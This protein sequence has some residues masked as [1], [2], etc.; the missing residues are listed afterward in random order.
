MWDMAAA[1]HPWLKPWKLGLYVILRAA[2]AVARNAMPCYAHVAPTP[3][4]SPQ[5]M[6][7]SVWRQ[8]AMAHAPRP[9]SPTVTVAGVKLARADAELALPVEQFAAVAKTLCNFPSFFAAPLF[10]RVL[11]QFRGCRLSDSE[12]PRR[13]ATAVRTRDNGRPVHGSGGIVSCAEPRSQDETDI[14]APGSDVDHT[15]AAGVVPLYMFLRYWRSEMEPF[16]RTDRFFRLVA[17]RC[18][19][20]QDRRAIVPS[21]FTPLLEELLA[22]HPG[23]GFLE[24][25]PEFQEKYARTVIARIFFD[26]DAMARGMIWPRSLRRSRLVDA[27]HTVDMEEDINL[28]NH[29][30]SY[31]HFYVLY[32]KFWE[33]DNDHDFQLTRADLDRMSD[34]T[35]TVLDRVFAQAGRP[36]VSS[37][38]GQQ[39][40]LMG[41]EDFIVFLMAEE[42]KTSEASIRYWFN[43]VDLNGD[44]VITPSEMRYFYREQ[45]GRMVELG[46]EAVSFDD[47]CVQMT[48][49]LQPE[50]PGEFRLTDFL[51]PTRVKLT[52]V[53]F[54]CLFNLAKFQSFEAREAVLVKQQLN[55]D[56]LSQWDRYAS[57][58]YMRLAEEEDAGLEEDLSAELENVSMSDRGAVDGLDILSNESKW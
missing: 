14:P 34:L 56:E 45:H 50:V 19:V 29:Y 8:G 27:F 4:A 52:G 46:M 38:E 33:L 30:F 32:C 28:V 36:F 16:D 11:A 47:F 22:F 35:L 26:L 40:K 37:T 42:D 1:H 15:D 41:Y 10:R 17:K 55:T 20:H 44:G 23:L 31:E 24:N 5:D 49:L 2:R 51:N 13:P 9:G 54:S 25:T 7:L 57:M 12:P 6:I 58:E 48:D 39:S 43:V 53:F 21:D 18:A 3:A